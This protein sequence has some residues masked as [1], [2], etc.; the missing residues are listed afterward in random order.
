MPANGWRGGAE[1]GDH[2]KQRERGREVKKKGRA[3]SN[4]STV[5]RGVGCNPNLILTHS[6]L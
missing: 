4:F 3:D 5:A 1:I 6:Q 2:R